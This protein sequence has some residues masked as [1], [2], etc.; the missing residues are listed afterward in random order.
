[1]GARTLYAP[2]AAL[3]HKHYYS[4]SIGATLVGQQRSAMFSLFRFG[5]AGRSEVV[6]GW[7]VGRVVGWSGVG[8]LELQPFISRS[9]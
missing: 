6:S 9:L 4:T 8:E 1:M 2:G 7:V 3:E 5:S